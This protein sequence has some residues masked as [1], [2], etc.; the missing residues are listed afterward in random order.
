MQPDFGIHRRRDSPLG[1][2]WGSEHSL[3][4]VVGIAADGQFSPN[5]YDLLSIA[6]FATTR[7]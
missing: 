6:A 4:T 1:S 5:F 2:M 7:G 3:T